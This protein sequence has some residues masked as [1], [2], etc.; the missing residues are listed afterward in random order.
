MCQHTDSSTILSAKCKTF[1][2]GEYSVLFGGSAVLLATNP[3]FKLQITKNEKSLLVG[4][5]EESPAFLFYM[6]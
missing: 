3:Q 4:V 5:P 1:L 2:V 6:V